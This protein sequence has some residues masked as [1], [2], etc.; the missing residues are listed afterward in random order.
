[1]GLTTSWY[2]RMVHINNWRIALPSLRDVFPMF[3]ETRAQVQGSRKARRVPRRDHDIHRRQV[4]LVHSKGLAGQPFDAV[5]CHGGAER[6]CRNGQAQPWTLPIIGQY[7]Q[8]KIGVE[9]LLTA[10]PDGAK[11][12]RLMQ[13]LARLEHQPLA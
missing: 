6:A 10:L 13:S 5:T 3:R 7:R 8:T 11:F 4:V 12:G 1:M 9:K 2:A